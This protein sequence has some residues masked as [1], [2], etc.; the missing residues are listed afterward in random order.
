MDKSSACKA[1][2]VLFV[3][4]RLIREFESEDRPDA[5]LLTYSL[6]LIA[7]VAKVGSAQFL[8]AANHHFLFTG[9]WRQISVDVQRASSRNDQAD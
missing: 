4:S 9:A 5:K 1:V 2:R 8:S 7:D 3:S 6:T